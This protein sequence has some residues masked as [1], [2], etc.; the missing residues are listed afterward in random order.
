M[1]LKRWKRK[2]IVSKVSR[3]W[4]PIW[5][6][7]VCKWTSTVRSKFS[8]VGSRNDHGQPIAG[9]DDQKCRRRVGSCQGT[10]ATRD[11]RQVVLNLLTPTFVDQYCYKC[12]FSGAVNLTNSKSFDFG[13]DV[14]HH[15]DLWRFNGIFLTAAGQARY[16]ASAPIGFQRSPVFADYDKAELFILVILTR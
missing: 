4:V 12:L 6:A 7:G 14:D 3:K 1:E 9:G 2:T 5:R 11:L 13:A 10:T 16:Y 8:H 15:P